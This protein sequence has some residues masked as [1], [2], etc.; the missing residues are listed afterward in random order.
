LRQEARRK[1]N[2]SILSAIRDIQRDWN[3][4]LE[5]LKSKLMRAEM[6]ADEHDRMKDAVDQLYENQS[7]S[8]SGPSDLARRR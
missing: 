8:S 3:D 5:R 4:E 6:S 2:R 1:A 7:A